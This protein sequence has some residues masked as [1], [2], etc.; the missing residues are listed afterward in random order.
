MQASSWRPIDITLDFGGIDTTE[1]NTNII[2]AIMANLIV[3]RLKLLFQVQGNTAI[4]AFKSNP[5]IRYDPL[6]VNYNKTALQTDLIIF[7]KTVPRMESG[8]SGTGVVCELDPLTNRPN[9]GV[10]RINMENFKVSTSI[11]LD[12][13][14]D[15]LMHE[16]FHIMGFTAA[17]ILK[18][19]GGIIKTFD[20]VKVVTKDGN[21]SNVYSLKTPN[22]LKWA[23][24]Y[25][26]CPMIS[27]IP[28]EDQ[29]GGNSHWEQNIM[30]N[31]IMT[32]R[33]VPR[34]LVSNATLNF[35]IDSG[36]YMVDTNK[37]E[38]TYWGEGEGCGIINNDCSTSYREFYPVKGI[39]DCSGDF[40]S[41]TYSGVTSNSNECITQI[42]YSAS[43]CPSAAPQAK[44]S[45]NEK[46]G[47][48]SRCF[49]TNVN[50]MI[51][52]IAGCY[53]ANCTDGVITV[54][55]SNG[56]QIN[57]TSAGQILYI[58]HLLTIICPDPVVFCAAWNQRCPNDCSGNGKCHVDGTCF[59]NLFTTGDDCSI[60][61]T[62]TLAPNICNMQS[63][64]GGSM[65]EF[66]TSG[67]STLISA[68]MILSIS[69]LFSTQS[70]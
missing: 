38:K 53:G 13:N 5:C 47:P 69:F 37:A 56:R 41:K 43:N 1:T 29:K 4:R 39:K 54:T 67:S 27:G 51:E 16:C 61:K 46:F 62:C 2:K 36:W 25:F 48:G 22:L 50:K 65:T 63:D 11:G 12:L 15:M 57:C 34:M 70:F 23:A 55:I 58:S 32:P 9:I 40:I 8:A 20:N 24:D 14:F 64:A 31:E 60:A 10:I 26:T 19:P 45:F 28:L 7:V 59:C 18:F 30:G 68:F 42:I 44:S 21:F 6:I 52:N 33:L 49:L 66:V 3:P 35:F 17:M